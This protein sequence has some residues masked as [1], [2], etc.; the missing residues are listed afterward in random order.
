MNKSSMLVDTNAAMP[1]P[2]RA[3]KSNNISTVCELQV[4]EATYLSMLQEKR[5]SAVDLPLQKC[6]LLYG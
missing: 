3:G 1:T 6:S 5:S 2:T 4:N